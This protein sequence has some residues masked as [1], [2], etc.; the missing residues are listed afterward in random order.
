MEEIGIKT[1][2]QAIKYYEDEISKL[3]EIKE[4]EILDKIRPLAKLVVSQYKGLKNR[5][6]HYQ[7]IQIQAHKI[8][9]QYRKEGKEIP[10]QQ[11]NKISKQ[12]ENDFKNFY[13]V[14]IAFQS[15]LQK[16]QGI[17]MKVSFVGNR[18]II[19]E[20]DEITLLKQLKN[21]TRVGYSSDF[22][23]QLSFSGVTRKANTTIKPEK[24]NLNTQKVYKEILKR[25]SISKKTHKEKSKVLILWQIGP[26]KKAGSYTWDGVVAMNIGDIREIYLKF[27]YN[28]KKWKEINIEKNVEEFMIEVLKVDNVSGALVGDFKADDFEIAAKSLNAT[29]LKYQQLLDI[30]REITSDNFSGSLNLDQF[31]RQTERKGTRNYRLSERNAKIVA[32]DISSAAKKLLNND[33]T[34]SKKYDIILS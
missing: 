12:L 32:E 18:G 7:E 11:N 3:Q 25:A 13:T 1:A 15:A 28:N 10:I 19:Y 9:E 20:F 2:Y 17:K 5:I 31:F 29:L 23:M 24:E 27:I 21:I 26:G 14:V 33:L 8:R 34:F 6:K 30:A 22:Q 16:M 4:N